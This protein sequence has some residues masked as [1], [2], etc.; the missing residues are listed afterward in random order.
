MDIEKLMLEYLTQLI[1]LAAVHTP[2][3]LLALGVLVVGFWLIGRFKKIT[4]NLL[5]RANIDITIRPFLSKV[6]SIALRIAL[7]LSVANMVGVETTSFLALLGT[8]GLAVGLALQGS[9]SNFA[10]G[11]LILLLRPFK[12]GDFI[13]I[14]QGQLGTVTAIQLFHTY[15]QMPDNRIIIIPNGNLSNGSIINYSRGGTRRV[16]LR[17]GVSYQDDLKK[18]KEVLRNI[19]SQHPKV[20]PEPIPTIALMEFGESS[21]NFVVRPWCK[22][23][24]YWTVYFEINEGVKEAFD[25]QGITI[26]FPQRDVHLYQKNK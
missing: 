10:G 2:K 23:E 19:V 16:D 15:I 9:L 11:V 14:Q 24:D 21:I 8:L 13:E 26:P 7:L 18:V 5:E 1:Q 25:A 4:Q 3:I 12:V 17:Y 20:L 6:L 22:T